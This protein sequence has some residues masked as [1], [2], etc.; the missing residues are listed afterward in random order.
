MDAMITMESAIMM[1]CMKSS[2]GRTNAATRLLRATHSPSGSNSS[3]VFIAQPPRPLQSAAAE[4]SASPH[5]G[6]GLR[7]PAEFDA[8]LE[9]G[10][11]AHGFL[12]FW[13]S[14]RCSRFVAVTG[15]TSAWWLP[16][17]LGR[18]VA[19]AADMFPTVCQLCC[20]LA[21]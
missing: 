13:Q 9:C 5:P 8:F 15:Q 4:W 11:L 19:T 20:I 1:V 16:T 17:C 10:I 12:L 2:V 14:F 3:S 18:Q 7:R 21:A 6:S